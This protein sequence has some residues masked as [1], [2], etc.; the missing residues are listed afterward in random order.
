MRTLRLIG[1]T[2]I[3][4][5]SSVSL[6][7][8][9][10]DEDEGG[11]YKEVEIDGIYY[12]LDSHK[13]Y[14]E[15]TDNHANYGKNYYG[16]IYIPSSINYKDK[17][18]TVFSIGNGAFSCELGV[19]SI[20]LPTSVQV[21]ESGAFSSCENM[22]SISLPDGIKNINDGAFKDCRSL[23]SI[24]LPESLTTISD[25]CFSR[26]YSLK[27]LTIPNNV[28][29]I[30]I[31]AFM[32][33]KNLTKVTIGENVVTIESTAFNSCEKL[34]AISIP[35]N[36]SSIGDNSFR[37]CKALT[38][39]EIG[40]NVKTISYSAFTQ[41]PKL[42]EIYC[43][44]KNPPQTDESAFDSSIE[45]A[46]LYVLPEALNEYKTISPWNRFGEIIALTNR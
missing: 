25:C 1:M 24:H 39:L 18:Y 15:V 37:L 42:K 19:N 35:Q 22:I 27:S 41:C 6:S 9:S 31:E 45:N 44:A 8:C 5:L 17:I 29:S 26:C 3:T 7:A 11:S 46:K 12:N 30:G 28:K 21:I 34:T 23:T 2:L 36:V 16:D 33:C 40:G 4:V 32:S 20:S 43:Y 13:E 38:K 10:S 14:A